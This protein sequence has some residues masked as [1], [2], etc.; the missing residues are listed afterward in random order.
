MGEG[1]G[2]QGTAGLAVGAVVEAA[3]ANALPPEEL[4]RLEHVA[5]DV[6]AH[7]ENLAARGAEQIVEVLDAPASK[8]PALGI[9]AGVRA[10]LERSRRL[11]AGG[12]RGCVSRARRASLLASVHW[13]PGRRHLV[14]LAERRAKAVLE[15][16]RLLR[17]ND[18]QVEEAHPAVVFVRAL[19]RH[20]GKRGPR[21]W[22]VSHR[23][24]GMER[25]LLGNGMGV[26]GRAI[27]SCYLLVRDVE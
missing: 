25:A 26:R 23:Q 22:C 14:D 27:G 12:R 7:V 21:W 17:G 24:V 8:D 3:E 9:L 15:K 11:W 10:Q 19:V 13:Q 2:E 4:L 6:V 20:G 16:G 5:K 1:R 18:N